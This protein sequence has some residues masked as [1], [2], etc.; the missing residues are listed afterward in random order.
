MLARL[1]RRLILTQI[2]LGLSCGYF[3]SK[4]MGWPLWTMVLFGTAFPFVTMLTV[5]MI[6]ALV[7]RNRAEPVGHWWRS[8]IGEFW[9]GIRVFIFR[10]PW[11]MHAPT[12]LAATGASKKIPVVLVHGYLCNNRIWDD[13]AAVLRA[14]GHDVFAVN[15]EPLFC[16]I[17]AYSPIIER[18]V[19]ELIRHSGLQQVA[20][21]GHSMG[22]LAIRAWIRACGADQ[23]ARIITLGTPHAGTKIAKTTPTANAKQMSWRSD[24][25]QEL[26]AIETEAVRAL[27]FIGLTPQDNIVFNQRDQ[28]LEGISPVIFEGIGHVQ[29]C[30]EPMVIRWVQE[31]LGELDPA[32]AAT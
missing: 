8:L 17:D 16:S 15:L 28:V 21:V 3:A 13:M 20:L 7:S 30:L 25:L 1:L 27:M 5:D 32:L 31:R 19:T 23:V 14:Q 12:L 24:W 18:A 26:A 6:S 22:G 10:Q 4:A 9:A 2:V 29:M 11:A